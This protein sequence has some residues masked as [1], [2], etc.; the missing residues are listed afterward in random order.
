MVP[1]GLRGVFN[2]VTVKKTGVRFSEA[3]DK[4]DSDAYIDGI[5]L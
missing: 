2:L 4:N 3:C 1:R 5:N